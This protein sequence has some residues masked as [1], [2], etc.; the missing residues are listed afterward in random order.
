[1]LCV[2]D[3]AALYIT[4]V[5]LVVYLKVLRPQRN[6][7]ISSREALVSG[8]GST[9]HRQPAREREGERP[10]QRLTAADG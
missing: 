4:V 10:A 1:M 7:V 3:P 6:R 2:T 9:H 8:F 5:V